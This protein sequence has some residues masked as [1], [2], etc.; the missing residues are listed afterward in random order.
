M[1]ET[2]TKITDDK[3]ITDCDIPIL[4]L[5]NSKIA[6]KEKA[7]KEKEKEKKEEKKEKK[8]KKRKKKKK[9]KPTREKNRK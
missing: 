6:R 8:D 1:D 4:E 3:N 7:E 2:F 5:S 9:K